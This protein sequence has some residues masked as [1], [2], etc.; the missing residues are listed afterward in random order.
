MVSED[1]SKLGDSLAARVFR[2]LRPYGGTAC[3]DGDDAQRESWARQMTAA[4]LP[5]AIVKQEDSL[6]LLTRQGPLL[7]AADWS[8]DGANAANAGASQDRF[9][10]APLGMLWFDGSIRWQRKPGSAVVRV[11]QG[12]V[13]VYAD[14]L[15]AM[16]VYTGR[17]MWVKKAPFAKGPKLEMVTHEGTVYVA[18]GTNCL[19]LDAATGEQIAKIELPA[20]VSGS[21]STLRVQG[22]YLVGT[23]GKSLVCLDTK[24]TKL[25]WVY[26]CNRTELSTALGGGNVYCSELLNRRRGET[27]AKTETHTRALD[28]ETGKVVW[29]VRNG[30]RVQYSVQS[31]LLLTPSGIY[32]GKDGSRVRNGLAP[33]QIAGEK[34]VSGAP[35]HLVVYELESGNK[36]GNELKWNRRGCTNLRSSCNLV[37]TR[38]KAN[39]AYIDLETREI[40]PIWNIR[41][42]CS[43]NLYPANGILNVPNVSGGCECNYTPTSKGFAPLA[44]IK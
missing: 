2:V 24:T 16:D 28:L 44:V 40:T 30:A 19:A 31:D 29:E 25:K 43:N 36:L 10:K 7:G 26:A 37:T 18:S 13:F 22:D 39:A 20:E 38:F 15:H 4:K 17:K 33:A 5:A 23:R 3:L 11:G 14:E 12:R 34:I 35:D 32:R 42:G 41:A 9:I 21:W 1:T 27:P 8:H 6:L